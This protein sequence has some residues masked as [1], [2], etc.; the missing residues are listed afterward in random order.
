MPKPRYWW[1]TFGDFAPADERE[2]RPDPL[3]VLVFF[4]DRMEV[5]QKHRVATLM[6]ILGVKKTVVYDLFNGK[7]F[8]SIAR[9]RRLVKALSIP[10]QLLAL[11][12][13]YCGEEQWWH[14]YQLSFAAGSDGYPEMS[15]VI[16]YFRHHMFKE[17]NGVQQPWTQ[18]DLARALNLT[19]VTVSK[20][21]N[22][23]TPTSM[24]QISRRELLARVIQTTVKTPQAA[25]V[26]ALLGLDQ[27]SLSLPKQD[28]A[29]FPAIHLPSTS[30]D[31]ASLD[32][33]RQIHKALFEEYFS[34]HGQEA[35][36]EARLWQKVIIRQ[37][38][39]LAQ[40]SQHIDV[41]ALQSLYHQFI[42]DIAREQRRDDTTLFHMN[43][44]VALAQDALRLAQGNTIASLTYTKQLEAAARLRR[45]AAHFEQ[46][47]LSPARND[48]DAALALGAKM[49]A[50]HIKTQ[51]LLIAGNIHAHTAQGSIDGIK[52][53]SFFDQASQ[54]F[55]L[56]SFED[57]PF[58]IRSS[59]GMLYIK[60]GMALCAPKMSGNPLEALD[61]AERLTSPELARRRLLIDIFRAQALIDIKEYEQATTLALQALETS[62]RLRSK[63]NRD[64]IENL[65]T[66]LCNTP[67]K[68]EPLLV[69]LGVQLQMWK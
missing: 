30:L 53:L 32:M 6:E 28:T 65:H 49:P 41:L 58:F 25:L 36:E 27:R 9:C 59:S 21:E 35:L 50:S 67:Y 29:L 3:E 57:D 18:G 14:R 45:A 61:D 23:H 56:G 63:L 22:N 10:P 12:A 43:K 11:D 51:V 19:E 48:I 13:Q 15:K 66:Q 26:F 31:T 64:R 33:H 24:D 68:G 42:G 1:Q 8:D 7:G 69:R 16:V 39:P 40:G 2:Q 34:R 52:A 4:L 54:Q 44:A 38:A 55:A 37:I 60:R 17:V 20:M 47:T 62:R 5:S 46:G